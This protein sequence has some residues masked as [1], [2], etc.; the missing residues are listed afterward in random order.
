MNNR[1]EVFFLESLW[2]MGQESSVE[3]K[4]CKEITLY[5]KNQGQFMYCTGTF[6]P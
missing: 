4:R 1:G 3:I 5:V 2:S 6:W